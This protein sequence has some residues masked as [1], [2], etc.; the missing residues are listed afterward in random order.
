M[1]SG[2]LRRPFAELY[3]TYPGTALRL[4]A[5]IFTTIAHD[6]IAQSWKARDSQSRSNWEQIA[7]ILLAGVQVTLDNFLEAQ[8]CL[9]FT[10]RTTWK[11]IVMVG[12]LFDIEIIVHSSF[13][14]ERVKLTVAQAYYAI[15]CNA[16]FSVSSSIPLSTYSVSLRVSVSTPAVICPR[17]LT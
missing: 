15:I 16:F 6:R 12:N 5:A 13:L 8:R 14:P 7:V 2:L 9:L 11:L 4:S 10:T 1:L 17:K 3:L